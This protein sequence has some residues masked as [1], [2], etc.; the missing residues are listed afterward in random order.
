MKNNKQTQG[1]S[2]KVGDKIIDFG[3]VYRIFRIEKRQ[4]AKDQNEKIIHFKPYYKTEQNRDLSCSIPIK[5]IGLTNIRKPISRSRMSEL[6]KKLSEKED[7][8]M[9]VNTIQAKQKLKSDKPG[10]TIQILKGLWMDKQDETTNFTG[11]KQNFLK[12]SMQRLVEE[13][14]FVFDISVVQAGNK[15]RG[16]L[17]KLGN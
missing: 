5:N 1:R 10:V 16:K 6:L 9:V 3:Q 12:L 8:K 15:I 14:A 2:Y 4:I 7:K 11:N 13:V 17:K